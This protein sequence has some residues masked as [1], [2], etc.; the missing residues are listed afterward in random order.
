MVAMEPS[1]ILHFQ[2]QLPDLH[3]YVTVICHSNVSYIN[4]TLISLHC[5]FT[6]WLERQR[7]FSGLFRPVLEVNGL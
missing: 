1:D 3:P 7:L 2:Q 5:I 4:V 6:N